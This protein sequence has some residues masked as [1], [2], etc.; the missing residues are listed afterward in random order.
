[1]TDQTETLSG[2]IK[3][4]RFAMFTTQAA[5]G[6][7][8]SRPMTTQSDPGEEQDCL[9]FFASHTGEAV[10][11]LLREPAVNV[12]YANTSKDAYVSVSGRAAVVDD[13]A[14]KKQMWSKF[15]EAWFPGGPEDPDLALVRVQIEAAEYWNVRESKVTQLF[16]I[17]RAT[18]TGQPPTDMGE[19]AKL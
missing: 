18:V 5:D 3:D 4:I 1:M 15:A 17:A 11:D 12:A 7:L 13:D 14:R 6:S 9:W 10:A 2:L 8:R 19:H 16:K